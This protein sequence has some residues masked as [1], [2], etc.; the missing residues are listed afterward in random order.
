MD[1]SASERSGN[2][3]WQFP[4]NYRESFIIAFGLLVISYA[5]QYTT[6]ATI[7]PVGR[8]L[9]LILGGI[10]VISILSL[11]LFCKKASVV[12]WLRSV[13]ASVS[14]IALI[15]IQTIIMGTLPQRESVD[16]P[17]GLNAV[18][19]S[20][21]FLIAQVYFLLTLGMTTI[22]R[23]FPW[24]WKNWGF[25][26]NHLG[27]FIAMSAAILGS[28]D[29]QRYT[30][31]LY[32]GKPEWRAK[33]STGE[34]KELPFAF[35]LTSFNM[36]VYNPKIAFSSITDG[37]IETSGLNALHEATKG[38]AYTYNGFKIQVIDY[39]NDSKYTGEQY[40]RVNE[41]GST[42]AALIRVK[43]EDG[44]IDTTGWVSC[45]SFATSYAYMQLNNNKA[46]VMLRPE[47]KKFS[48]AVNVYYK[49][50]QGEKAN[51]EVNKPFATSG[52]K[53]YQLSYD[54]KFGKW[55]ELS[56]IELVRDPWLPVVYTG[57]FMMIAGAIYL[58]FKG[59]KKL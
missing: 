52:W 17:F 6:S 56:V 57:I 9:N 44:K 35:E 19:H 50:G 54:E 32:Q 41:V 22:N 26:L 25:L 33:S 40:A 10:F 14:A 15:V 37:K 34:L 1:I 4:W 39:L 8:P 23:M 59:N 31:D 45:G 2:R 49:D 29:L 21:P 16:T 48:S 11:H 3:L 27:L 24:Q 43:S 7:K 13:P 46:V 47:A 30:M 42:P 51:I 55:S 12:K 36:E 18:L 58:I 28:G 38:S 53:I 5:L 20:W